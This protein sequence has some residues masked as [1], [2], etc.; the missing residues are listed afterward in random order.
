LP[1]IQFS[2]L[3]LPVSSM[4][5]DAQAIAH[6][7]PATYFQHLSVGTFTKALGFQSVAGDLGALAIIVCAI[8]TLARLALRTQER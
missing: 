2:G 5:P 1:A 7:F 6:A 3:L 8:I 4:S